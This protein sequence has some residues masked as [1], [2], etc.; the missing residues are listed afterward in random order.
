MPENDTIAPRGLGAMQVATNRW[1]S[2]LVVE[3]FAR[4]NVVLRSG[5]RK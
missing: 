3:N 2:G 5:H 4:R 1:N